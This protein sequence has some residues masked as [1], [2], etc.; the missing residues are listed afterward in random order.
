[1]V[2]GTPC[3]GKCAGGDHQGFAIHHRLHFSPF[4]NPDHAVKHGYFWTPA[5]RNFSQF[6]EPDR[7]WRNVQ[8]FRCVKRK[9]PR[10][11]GPSR[12][13]NLAC[14]VVME[15]AAAMSTIMETSAATTMETSAAMVAA[16][17]A[18]M[19]AAATEA[20]IGLPVAID[21]ELRLAAIIAIAI[22]PA[23]PGAIEEDGSVIVI[24]IVGV[25]IGRVAAIGIVE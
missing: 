6:P 14:L 7:V 25:V 23:Q 13:D 5:L 15:P 3:G 21:E 18:R 19:E 10:K 9:R 11:P 1:M 17:T 4:D 12:N 2:R 20:D 16:M 22:R 24:V 8:Q